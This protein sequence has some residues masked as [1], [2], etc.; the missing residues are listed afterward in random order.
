M[1]ELSTTQVEA[2]CLLHARLRGSRSYDTKIQDLEHAALLVLAPERSAP[3]A[4]VLARNARR[5][6]RRIRTRRT[7]YVVLL[8]IDETRDEHG[9]RRNEQALNAHNFVDRLRGR[10][11]QTR[12]E[13]V[14]C[15]DA[16]L[17]DAPV[18]QTANAMGMTTRQ[19]KHLRATIRSVAHSLAA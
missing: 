19:V 2:L 15:L 9:D 12:P 13:C 3:S 10:L 4:S 7:R 6:A 11:Q 18:D 16:W 5:D 17:N 1:P 8:P 14:V